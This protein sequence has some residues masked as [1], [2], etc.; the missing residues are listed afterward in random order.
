MY[1]Q[2]N[3]TIKGIVPLIMHN[4]FHL[5]NPRSTITKL[6][7]SITSKRSK[8]DDDHLLIGHLEWIASL[9]M[10][11][12]IEVSLDKTNLVYSC[13]GVPCIPGESLEAML[14]QAGKK[15]KLG[16]QAKTG[17]ICDGNFPL[18]YTGPKTV[19]ELWENGN[20]TDVR[21]VNVQKN[22]VMRTRPIFK[23]WALNFNINYLSDTI[24][25]HQVIQSVE[26][27][28]AVSGL[29]DYRPKF[30]RFIIDGQPSIMAA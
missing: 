29:G 11:E 2:I 26:T 22:K 5:V 1:K 6:L 12:D 7:K 20:F 15:H 18:L 23:E 16:Q 27:A 25:E 8:V 10:T 9:Y 24:A 13:S 19:V 30:G 28:G 14:I 3:L 4:S 17:I 21:A